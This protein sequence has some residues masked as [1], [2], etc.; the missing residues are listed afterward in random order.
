MIHPVK[1]VLYITFLTLTLSTDK[2]FGKNKKIWKIVFAI[3]AAAVAFSFM[4]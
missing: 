1:L 4:Y 3:L 2:V